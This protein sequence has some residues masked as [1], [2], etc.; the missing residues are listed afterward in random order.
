ME[1]L[2]GV[3]DYL[4]DIRQDYV[5]LAWGDMA[6]N[7]PVNEV[8][9]QHKNSGADITMVCTPTLKGAPRFSEYV[10][11]SEEGRITDLSVH[12]TSADKALESLEIYILSKELLLELVLLEVLSE[13]AVLPPMISLTDISKSG[14]PCL[15]PRS[16]MPNCPPS[17][18]IRTTYTSRV[19]ARS[20][21]PGVRSR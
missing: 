3:Y 19:S 6:I 21:L 1:A 9:E 17:R 15:R 4:E 12:P 8:F 2:A 10:E 14:S 5:L 13:E 20:I 16:A 18:P 11:V 7:L